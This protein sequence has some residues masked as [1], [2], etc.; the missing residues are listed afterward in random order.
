M[1]S[2]SKADSALYLTPRALLLLFGSRAGSQLVQEMH[3][4]AVIVSQ[5]AQLRHAV[6]RQT[7]N[8]IIFDHRF[9]QPLPQFFEQAPPPNSWTTDLHPFTLGH[10]RSF[11][12]LRIVECGLRI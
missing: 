1:R 10:S 3:L 5:R 2:K 8:P 11:S 9:R 7:Y 4:T 6:R 12:E